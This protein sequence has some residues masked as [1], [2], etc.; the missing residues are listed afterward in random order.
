MN[1]TE[2]LVN[3]YSYIIYCKVIN[4]LNTK[5]ISNSK[6]HTQEVSAAEVTY[7]AKDCGEAGLNFSNATLLNLISTVAAYLQTKGG[8]NICLKDLS[9]DGSL[10]L[11]S[12]VSLVSQY[13]GKE[14]AYPTKSLNLG[15]RLFVDAGVPSEEAYEGDLFLDSE[16]GNL[17]KLISDVWT[18]QVTLTL[19]LAP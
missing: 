10:T 15:G 5:V 6:G 11:P 2:P 17:Y 7:I 12:K 16:T 8:G 4:P 9:Y 3:E 1:I 18:L 19:T 14:T 13:Q